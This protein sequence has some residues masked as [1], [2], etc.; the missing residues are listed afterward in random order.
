MPQL[1]GASLV[2]PSVFIPHEYL[3]SSIGE[4]VGVSEAVVVDEDELADTSLN[5]E[6]GTLLAR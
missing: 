4:E 2:R 3:Y 5:K 6:E 1:K